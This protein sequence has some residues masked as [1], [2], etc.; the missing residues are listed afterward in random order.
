MQLGSKKRR[1]TVRLDT[2]WNV[3]NRKGQEPTKPVGQG[4]GLDY[5]LKTGGR[6]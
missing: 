3:T 6:R 1:K 4:K 2:E 5:I